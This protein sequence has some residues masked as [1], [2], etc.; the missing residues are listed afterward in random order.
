MKV[1]SAIA[2]VFVLGVAACDDDNPVSPSD[3][4]GGTWR[5]ISIQESGSAPTM[6]TDP[7]RY[8]L[9]LVDGGQA[10][11][12]SD[13]NSCGGPYVLSGSSLDIGPV[14]CTRAFCGDDSLDPAYPA[15]LDEAQT[16]S[17]EDDELV[18]EGGGNTLRFER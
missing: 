10:E 9:R 8:T 16:I 14:V 3:V 12:M 15:A 11:I 4:L 2:L 17:L 6:V 18:I 5:L 7:T 1:H 13:C